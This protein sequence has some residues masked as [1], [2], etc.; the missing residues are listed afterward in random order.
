MHIA[1]VDSKWLSARLGIVPDQVTEVVV[2]PVGTGQIA[3]TYRASFTVDGAPR[4][5]ILKL[6][7]DDETSSRVAGQAHRNYVREVGFYRDVA[8]HLTANI[9]RCIYAGIDADEIEF[10]IAMDDLAPAEQGDQISGCTVGQ[11]RAALEQIARVHAQT[12]DNATVMSL[13]WLRAGRASLPDRQA[14]THMFEQYKARY[15]EA[16]SEDLLRVGHDF[17]DC[18]ENYRKLVNESSPRSLIHS[19]FRLDNVMIESTGDGDKVTVLDWQTVLAGPP[20]LDVG[21][22]IATSFPPEVRRRNEIDLVLAYHTALVENG[23]SDYPFEDCWIDYRRFVAHA[24]LT[25]IGA[26]AMVMRTERGDRMF[27]VM[28]Q[29]SLCAMIDF[30]TLSLLG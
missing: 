4:T 14:W 3:D 16:L 12:H 1:D 9:P 13:P 11:A 15:T 21:F 26:S 28:T 17:A 8:P 6:T 27:S 20:L 29:R 18:V 30:D 22:F 19:D 23:V 25:S 7:S 5:L 24:F 10:V 2:A